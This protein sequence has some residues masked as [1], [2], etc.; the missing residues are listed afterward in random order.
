[1]K[2]AA[3]EELNTGAKW[4]QLSFPQIDDRAFINNGVFLQMVDAEVE[5]D[6]TWRFGVAFVGVGL[7][8]TIGMGV[9]SVIISRGAIQNYLPKRELTAVQQLKRMSVLCI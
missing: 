6:G 8:F 2:L 9:V 5:E 7:L 4:Q 1:M 3:V